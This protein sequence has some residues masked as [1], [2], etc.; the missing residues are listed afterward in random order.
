MKR[1]VSDQGDSFD[2]FLDTICNTF[3]GIVF[4]AILVALIAK[5]RHD[6]SG[7][8]TAE[9]PVTV[10]MMR[11]LE[12][13]LTQQQSRL[14]DLQNV[15]DAM[16]EAPIDPKLTNLVDRSDELEKLSEAEKKLVESRQRLGEELIDIAAETAGI[17]EQIA[18]AKKEFEEV[19]VELAT[20]KANWKIVQK[21]KAKTMQVPRERTGA[22]ARGIVLLSGG[23][24][25]LVASP[26]D[27]N[28]DFFDKHVQSNRIPGSDGYEIKPRFGKGITL[29][30]KKSI[31][32]IRETARLLSRKGNTLIIAVYPDSYH[33]FGP[34][35]D[36]FKS[37][38]MNYQLWI[39]GEDDPLQVFYGGGRSRVQ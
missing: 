25:F 21:Q 29:G 37:F 9:Q 13:E 39:Q 27:A 26:D 22:G 3:G 17:P 35:R 5:I 34:V 32:A 2:L 14:R 20:A 11:T 19:A 36:A 28:G 33:Q 12:L 7:T 6:P 23:E 10:L 15:H 8:E 30:S 31:T 4:L 18:K 1:R 24:V 38:G 16:P